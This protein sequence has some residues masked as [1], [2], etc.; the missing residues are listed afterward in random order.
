MMVGRAGGVTE[1]Q[2][3]VVSDGGEA[4]KLMAHKT[5]GWILFEAPFEKQKQHLWQETQT[6]NCCQA[7][8]GKW[9]VYG[10]RKDDREV[11][12]HND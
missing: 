8:R 10:P 6:D 12:D 11:S 5:M 9:R 7:Y 2:A 1:R 4:E 3:L